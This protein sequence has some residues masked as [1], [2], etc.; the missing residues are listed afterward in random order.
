MVRK[1]SI[2][3]GSKEEHDRIVRDTLILLGR[4]AH[5]LCRVWEHPTGQAY[6][7]HPSGWREHIRYGLPGSSDIIGILITSKFLALEIKSGNAKQQPNQL[8]FES[9]IKRFGGFYFIVR[10]AD[11]A[12]FYVLQAA[13]Q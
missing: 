5:Q 13:S 6:R 2:R 12:L 3:K 8:A 4:E 7:D 9:M 11:E 10:S 1:S